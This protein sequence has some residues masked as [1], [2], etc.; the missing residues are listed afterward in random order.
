[1]KKS[2]KLLLGGFLALLLLISAIHVSLYAKYKAGNYTIYNAEEDLIPQAIESFPNV[3]LVSVRNVRGATVT[4]GDVAQMEK[5]DESDV[6]Y[7]RKGDTLLIAGNDSTNQGGFRHAVSFKL[8]RNATLTA[9]NSSLSFKTDVKT[10]ENNPVIYLQKSAAVFDG[11][12]GSLRLGHVKV[13]ASNGSTVAFKDNTQVNSLDVQLSGSSFEYDDGDFGQLSIVT[14][15]LSRISLPS[16]HLLK[17]NIKTI[18][19]Q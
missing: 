1:M 2:N 7:V 9:F 16:K 14:D 18:A 15:S 11:T 13:I 19:S 10:G 6:H 17:A 3:L 12:N 8:P 4:F 5:S